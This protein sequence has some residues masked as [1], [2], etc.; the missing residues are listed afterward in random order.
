MIQAR[1]AYLAKS[2]KA[3]LDISLELLLEGVDEIGC[4]VVRS[5]CGLRARPLAAH[6]AR[7]PAPRRLATWQV[8]YCYAV[9]LILRANFDL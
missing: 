3:R 1:Q 8:V 4:S 2:V 7:T 9:R 5:T 6:C